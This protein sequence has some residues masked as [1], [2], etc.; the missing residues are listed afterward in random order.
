MTKKQSI[1]LFEERK[2]RTVWDNEHRSGIF[3][4]LM[5]WLCLPNKLIVES[6]QVFE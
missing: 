6:S 4:L 1:Q 3:P 5:L 2:V